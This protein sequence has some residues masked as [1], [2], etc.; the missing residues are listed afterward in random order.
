[1][2]LIVIKIQQKMNDYSMLVYAEIALREIR[3]Y[4]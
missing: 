2:R 1:M 3:R 4:Y